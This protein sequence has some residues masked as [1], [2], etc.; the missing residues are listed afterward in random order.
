MSI[1]SFLSSFLG[2]KGFF[3]HFGARKAL[4]HGLLRPQSSNLRSGVGQLFVYSQLFV[5]FSQT[6]QLKAS[7]T[8]TAQ[9]K[10]VWE[11]N[12][13]SNYISC[14]RSLREFPLLFTNTI[15]YVDDTPTDRLWTC[16]TAIHGL[17]THLSKWP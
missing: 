4:E 5:Y 3:M 11:E 12:L 16:M 10:D 15:F 9:S 14:G 1:L 8:K 17:T 2:I 6:S 13:E 7:N